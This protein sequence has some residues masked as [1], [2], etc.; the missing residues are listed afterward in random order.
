VATTSDLIQ[1]I[2]RS[3]ADDLD[4]PAVIEAINTWVTQSQSESEGGEAKE[5]E[6]ALDSLLGIKL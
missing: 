6:T 2:V 3:I 4:T 1:Q 5:L